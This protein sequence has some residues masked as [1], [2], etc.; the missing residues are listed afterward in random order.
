MIRIVGIQR[1]ERPEEEFVL[2]QNQ[3][4]MRLNLRGHVILTD[5]AVA[6]VTGG[7]TAALQVLE[8]GGR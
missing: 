2:L 8:A 5:A 7:E 4:G 1:A 3:G 6:L